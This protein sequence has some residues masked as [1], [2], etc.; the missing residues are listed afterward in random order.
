MSAFKLGD[1][2]A[3]S[4]PLDA[5]RLRAFQLD[6]DHYGAVHET[7][8]DVNPSGSKWTSNVASVVYEPDGSTEITWTDGLRVHATTTTRGPFARRTQLAVT[9]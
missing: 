1:G 7:R 5:D 3:H 4:Y 9:A 6:L 2:V 8:A